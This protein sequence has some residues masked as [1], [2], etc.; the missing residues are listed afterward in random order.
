MFSRSKVIPDELSQ[1]RAKQSVSIL[2]THNGELVRKVLWDN[3]KEK[4]KLNDSQVTFHCM[5]DK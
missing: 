5:Y 3:H 1:L 4:I 2:N